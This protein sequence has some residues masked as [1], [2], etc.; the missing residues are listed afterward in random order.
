[1]EDLALKFTVVR[2]FGQPKSVISHPFG[3]LPKSVLNKIVTESYA[4]SVVKHLEELSVINK[5]S[6]TESPII[7]KQVRNSKLRVIVNYRQMNSVL[8]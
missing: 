5:R 7:L 1:M 2:A 6:T 8:Q 3:H 4:Y